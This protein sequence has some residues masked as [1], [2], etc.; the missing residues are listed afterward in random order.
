VQGPRSTNP[1]AASSDRGRMSPAVL[2]LL[3]EPPPAGVADAT[4]RPCGDGGGAATVTE[5]GDLPKR[6][7]RFMGLTH[8]TWTHK[9]RHACI[10][11]QTTASTGCHI[12]LPTHPPL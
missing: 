8:G 4:R 5:E 6:A 3:W 2:A 10:A 7:L 11:C 9:R 12:L 1:V